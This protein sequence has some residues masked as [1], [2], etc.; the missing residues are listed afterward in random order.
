[1]ELGKEILIHNELMG[2][3][4][5]KGSLVQVGDGYYEVNITFG[6]NIHRVMLPIGSTVII[7]RDAEPTVSAD[8]EIER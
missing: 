6:S 7:S 5:G 3:K 4:G 2:L 8:F 1:M